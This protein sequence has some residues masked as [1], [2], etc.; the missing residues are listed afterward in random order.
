MAG[1]PPPGSYNP[2]SPG[3]TLLFLP[4]PNSGGVYTPPSVP[5]GYTNVICNAG[6]LA[7][8]RVYH[9]AFR[10]SNTALVLWV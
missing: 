2:A 6:I 5:M 4:T 7:F 1:Y 9:S 8:P 10:P 3:M